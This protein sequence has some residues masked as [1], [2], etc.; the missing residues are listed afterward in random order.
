MKKVNIILIFLLFTFLL[1]GCW[2]VNETDELAYILA[3]GIDKGESNIIKV[4]F[5]IAIPSAIAGGEGGGGDK[6]VLNVSVEAASILGALQLAN[7]FVS[8]DLTFIHNRMVIVSEEIAREGLNRYI[9]P[10]IRSREIRRNTYI[11]VTRGS[12]KEFLEKNKPSLELNTAKQFELLLGE[13]NDVGFMSDTI[14]N[15]FY[16]SI[17]SPGK[18]PVLTL[19]GLSQ[20]QDKKEKKPDTRIQMIE[21]EVAFLPGEIPREGGNEVEV[22]GLAVF[23]G[24]KL[25]GYLDGSET[26]YYQMVTGKFHKAIFTFP[27]PEREETDVIVIEVKSGRKPNTGVMFAQGKPIIDVNIILEGEIRSLQSGINYETGEKLNELK[28]YL[29]KIITDEIL[30]LVKKTREEFKSDIF[31]FGEKTRKYFWTYPAWESYDWLKVYP[32]TL[33]NVKVDLMIRRSGLMIRTAPI[34]GSDQDE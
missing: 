34:Q 11:M 2:G 18:Q 10:L 32:E 3:M 28:K 25:A 29:E 33:V 22:I 17:K 12:S 14:I 6:P 23:R 15:D 9:N 16:S 27:D 30:T 19:V 8:R 7:A 4:S 26:R 5:Q 20:K 24:D 31:G 21:K 1:S 13:T